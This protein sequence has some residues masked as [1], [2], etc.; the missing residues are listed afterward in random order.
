[1][2]LSE[3]AKVAGLVLSLGLDTFAV[4]VGLGLAGLGRRERLRF[5]VAFATA[6]GL[7]P[8]AGFLAGQ[9]T[10]RAVG[11]IAPYAAIALL[12]GVGLYAV[13]EGLH[14]EG[15]RE[16][17]AGSL[18]RLGVLALSVSMDELAVGFSLGLL[19]IPVLL[20]AALIAAQA[21]L[22]TIIGT[23][24]GSALGEEMAERSEVLSGVVLAL[25]AVY[26]LIEQVLR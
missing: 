11:R 17:E 7:M 21:F 9:V 2:N 6:E 18:L 13:W 16:L 3:A 8:L 10:A 4:A 23:T 15:E 19:G 5:G 14:E 1:M 26:L 24:I 25:L 22:I 20:A 12:F